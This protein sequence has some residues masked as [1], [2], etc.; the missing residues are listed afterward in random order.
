MDYAKPVTR[1]K[2]EIIVLYGPTGTGKSKFAFDPVNCGDNY[3]LK[4]PLTKWWD[5]YRSQETIIMDEFRGVIAISHFLRWTDCY[6]CP[7]EKKGT[8]TYLNTKKWIITSNLHPK[9]W[10]PELDDL[11]KQAY[12]RRITKII[13]KTEPWGGIMNQ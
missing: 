2:Q 7:A 13:H 11:S 8:Q 12:L 5:G 10:Y 6:P 1:E 9:D 4:Q 3:Y